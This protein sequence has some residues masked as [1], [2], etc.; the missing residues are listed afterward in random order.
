MTDLVM[1][2]MGKMY[3]SVSIKKWMKRR[4]RTCP[5]TD[6]RLLIGGGPQP[7]HL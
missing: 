2:A 4:C 1:M 3:D 5:V 7:L 6:E